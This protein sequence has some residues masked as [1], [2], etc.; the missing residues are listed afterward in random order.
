MSPAL[1]LIVYLLFAMSVP[2]CFE[3]ANSISAGEVLI[4]DAK[5]VSHNG[6]FAL[7]FFHLGSKHSSQQIP[8]WYLGIWFDKISKLT[9]IWVANRDDPIIGHHRMSELTISEDGNLIIFN[10]ATKSMVWSTHA[11]ITVKNTTA[12]LM[13]NGNLI[14]TDASNF[15][16]IIWQ[17]F[18][19][20]TDIMPPGAKFGLDKVTGLNR[21]L[22]SKRSLVN[23]ARARYCLELDPTGA[24]QF[25]FKLCNTSIVY[26]STGEWNGQYFNSMPEMSGRTLFDFKFI[27]NNEEYFQCN[28]LDK[29]LTSISLL[30]IS[31]QNKLLIWLED[32][33]EWTTIYIQ[34]KDRCD[35]YATCGPFTI[36]D[37]NAL[38]LCNCMRGF[39]V[40]SPKDWEQEDQTGGCIR[41]TPLDC[42]T[43]DHSRTATTDKFYSLTGV[44][45]PVEANIELV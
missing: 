11:T 44:T 13:D 24:P 39:S 28:L 10:Q 17:S 40:R 42:S 41:N 21:R 27:N 3:A 20:P 7:G 4:S 1:V 43:M 2:A 38:S 26:W 36:C 30:D 5:L 32:K 25:V 19:Y 35:V 29:N 37:N 34:P 22:V 9:P 33:Q 16:N 14:L 23:P 31:G 8:N 18:D 12:V 15:S 45:L 6:R